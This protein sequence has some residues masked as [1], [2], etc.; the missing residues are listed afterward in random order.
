MEP[1][2]K[3]F[4]LINQNKNI[5]KNISYKIFVY[6]LTACLTLLILTIVLRL[7]EAD[8]SIPFAYSG[9]ALDVCARFK[10]LIDNGW[11]TS[12]YFTGAPFGALWYDFPIASA[13]LHWLIIKFIALF[14]NNYAL[15]M[16]LYYIIAFVL[17]AIVS[18]AVLQELNFDNEIA[19]PISILY[20]FLP[21]HFLRGQYHYF[22]SAYFMVPLLLLI[23]Y[24]LYTYERFIFEISVDTKRLR[25]KANKLTIVS[26]IICFATGCA[27][28]Y[29]AFFG[30]FF[31]AI[32]GVIS[33]VIYRDVSRILTSFILILAISFGTLVSFLPSIVYQAENG[34][35]PKVANRYFAESEIY[36]LKINQLVLPISNHRSSVLAEKRSMFDQGTILNNENSFSSLGTLGSIGFLFLTIMTFFPGQTR[37]RSL[38]VLIPLNLSATLLATVGGF[39]SLFAFLISPSIRGYNRI[40]I[41]IAYFSLIAI[42]VLLK[43]LKQKFAKTVMSK[44]MFGFM[45]LGILVFGIWDQTSTA[46][47]PHYSALKE[48][49]SNDSIFI[50]SIENK[51]EPGSM[52]F[53]L[54][55]VPWPENPPVNRMTDYELYRGYLHSESL[56]WSYGAMKGR[57]SDQWLENVSSKNTE[58]ML[59]IISIAGFSGVYVDRFGYEDNGASIEN[60][61]NSILKEKPLEDRNRRLMLFDLRNYTKELKKQY[62]EEAWADEKEQILHPVLFNWTRGFFSLEGNAENNWRW[63]SKNGQLIINNMSLEE[64]QI[65]IQMGFV[66][67]HP[68]VSTM[69]IRSDSFNDIFSVNNIET[70]Y[71]KELAIPPGKTVIEFKCD[72]KRVYAPDDPRYLVF[73]VNNFNIKSLE[74]K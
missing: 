10:G 2:I 22:L 56:R 31:L 64:K 19:I 40:S 34:N 57:E 5:N 63:C 29:Y 3:N 18:L 42:A 67:G 58:D 28:V 25:F 69:T 7:W 59:R 46:Y 14:S 8:L 23:A 51:L 47:I 72:A 74:E 1:K 12:N 39:G 17:I 21:Y 41:F 35:N 13:P 26:L 71:K 6:S 45:M 52:V 16:N 37:D 30:C 44:A 11:P 68:E 55:Y 43:A 15:V 61:L 20:A 50:S 38:L 33:S 32:I 24:R 66:S 36:G 70:K 62:T 73:R 60:E 9:D 27:G 48:S 54:P 65:K 53:Q 49:Y 4:Q